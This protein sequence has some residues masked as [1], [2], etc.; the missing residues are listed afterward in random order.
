MVLGPMVCIWQVLYKYLPN[1]AVS[2]SMNKYHT[3][4][5]GIEAFNIFLPI[6]GHSR[7][8]AGVGKKLDEFVWVY[9]SSP[10]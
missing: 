1:V 8:W 7:C 10:K 2:G 4:Y 6:M 5:V 9:K 3:T